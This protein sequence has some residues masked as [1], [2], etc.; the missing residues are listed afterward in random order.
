MKRYI[1]TKDGKIFDLQAVNHSVRHAKIRKVNN[2]DIEIVKQADTI[3]ELIEVGDLVKMKTEAGLDMIINVFSLIKTGE[4]AF[5][6]IYKNYEDITEL[7]T[8]QGRNYV[9]VWTKEEEVI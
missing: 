8:K 7:Y 9:L 3:E 1:R 5:Q 2:G 4:M 6:K